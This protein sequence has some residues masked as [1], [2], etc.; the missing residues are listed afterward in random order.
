MAN[1]IKWWSSVGS[2]GTVDVADISKV[3]FADSVVQLIGLD[4]VSNLPTPLVALP[5]VQTHAVIRY[6]VT[7]VEAVLPGNS[8]ALRLRYR[9]GS[10]RVV[11]N[12]I[13]VDIGSGA[14]KPV[15]SFDSQTSTR[16]NAFQVNVPGLGAQ[17]DFANHAYY[18]E[19]TLTVS[20][21]PP[22]PVFFPPKV[23]VIQL[24]FGKSP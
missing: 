14:E 20:S 7:P 11:A 10:G 4:L 9:D 16:S 3:V 6:G 13:E 5:V 18:V 1:P 17:L 8:F 24:V 21:H 19:L 23:S 15:T 2:A 12:L 22:V